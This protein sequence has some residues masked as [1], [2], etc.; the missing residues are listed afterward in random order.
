MSLLKR[1]ARANAVVMLLLA[2]LLCGVALMPDQAQL[3]SAD[4]AV[5]GAGAQADTD[6]GK[7][8]LYFTA[9]QG[10]LD[11]AVAYYVQGLDKTLYFTSQ[12]LTISLVGL[13]ASEGAAPVVA[14]GAGQSARAARERWTV[15]L[16]YVGSQVTEPVGQGKTDAIVS[17]M[18]GPRD[19]WQVGVPTY[20]SVLS[21]DV[22]PGIDVIYSGSTDSLKQ[23]FVLEPGA[24]AAQ[25][26]L[27]YRGAQVTLTAD[28]A[29]LVHAPQGSFT[30][31]APVA[32]QEV[33]GRR[34]IVPV[35]FALGEVAG[36]GAQE[37]T[38]YGFNLGAYD[39]GLPLVI[40]PAVLVY[41]GYI[42]GD[43]QD[44]GSDIAIDS[45]GNAYVTGVTHSSASSFPRVAGPDWFREDFTDAFVAK[46]KAD[47][48][49]LAYCG[50][51]GGN[52]E[53]S[54]NAIAVDAAG[55]AYITGETSSTDYIFPAFPPEIGPWVGPDFTNNG[56][57][58]AF[59]AKVKADGKGLVYCGFIGGSGDDCGYG[60]AVDSAGAAYVTGETASATG[61]PIRGTLD[62]T[63]NGKKDAF[64]AKVRPD[65]W[66]LVYCGYIG[67]AEDDTASGI[68]VDASGNAYITGQTRSTETTFPEK[69]GPDVTHNGNSDAFVAKVNAAGSALTYCGYIGGSGYTDGGCGIALDKSGNAYVAGY[70]E[71]RED[72]FPV[73]VGPDLTFNGGEGGYGWY[74]AFVAKVKADGTSLAYCGYIGGGGNDHAYDIAVDALGGAY[75][76]GGTQSTQSTF[77]VQGGPDLTHNGGTFMNN[78]DAFVAKLTPSGAALEYCGYIGGSQEDYG[79][80][81]ALDK[82]GNAY[83]V[84]STAS[85][86]SLGFP[87]VG[88]AAGDS[89]HNG[90]YDAFVAKVVYQSVTALSPAIGP[91][92]GGT[93]VVITGTGFTKNST[94]TFGGVPAASCTYNSATKLTVVTPAHDYGVVDVV[95]TTDGSAT[96]ATS[97]ADDYTY[98]NRYQQTETKLTYLG[99][100]ASAATWSAS[101]GSYY[102]T[103]TA[104]SSALVSFTGTGV[105][106]V[107]VTAPW[108]GK[109]TVILDGGA[110][111]YADFYAKGQAYKQTVYTKSGLTDGPHT[112]IIKY[113]GDKNPSAS[114]TSI[115]LDALDV[116]GTL[117]QAPKT[118]RIDDNNSA[119]CTY[120]P[121]WSRW[122]KSGYWAAYQDTYACSDK[123]GA[124]L[125]VTF[126][127]TYLSWVSRYSNTQGKAQVTLDPGTPQEKT[128]VVDLFS[129]STLWKKSV[130]ATGLLEY[131]PHTVVIECLY[132]KNPASWWYTIGVDAFDILGPIL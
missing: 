43:D 61:F 70:T 67:G 31:A 37:V 7:M 40:D 123:K 44:F 124:K 9:N 125:T 30:D 79:H 51:V 35:E 13:A 52:H 91:P 56:G 122:D 45:S 77:P 54:G 63:H 17:Y 62:T 15:K 111:E 22:W 119:Y 49:G 117:T 3:A 16:D 21:E 12:G 102:S 36:S 103:N 10:R 8:P 74:D 33:D 112:L 41:C 129:Y 42:G 86:T 78:T 57:H 94:V 105:N 32:Y 47:G 97:T 93:T 87:V 115:N 27:A 39:R 85:S 46:V 130:Y 66:G 128:Q 28:G 20:S 120:G 89:T 65:G 6:W 5:A 55:C 121:L 84:G 26:R 48:T 126:T 64:V 2:L 106:L 118:T 75:V 25:V 71:S 114:G 59:V 34:V 83:V 96:E 80:G 127:G 19:D 82:S 14:E 1:I 90:S 23:E 108:Y 76:T 110:A 73:T 38:E 107:G 95:V 81:I 98:T 60:I 58:D 69:I 104:G 131:G 92:A 72:T 11:R 132:E 53:D 4:A 109:A 88:A 99:T 100:W 101:G 24:D 50:Y 18:V 29:L 68:A 116:L 113:T